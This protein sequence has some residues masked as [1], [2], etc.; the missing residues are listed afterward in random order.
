[1]N[2][3]LIWKKNHIFAANN[4]ENMYIH[5][6]KDWPNFIWEEGK[7]LKLLTKITKKQGRLIGRMESI[8]FQLQSE[9]VLRSITLEV[10]KSN[11]IE[12]E[13]LNP[14]QVRSSVARRLGL[15]IAGLIPSDRYVDGAVEMMLD[16]TQAYLLPLTKT[17]LFAWHNLLFPLNGN[18]SSK[19]VI[20]KWRN[21]KLDDPMQVVSGAM[22]KEKV[23]FQAPNS[24]LLS[25]EM[26]TFLEWFNKD[27]ELH[28]LLKAAVSHLWFVTLHPFDDGNGRVARAIAD[29]QLTRADEIPQ[30]FY[31]MS[32]Q[33]RIE[34]K[35]YY[36]ILEKTQKGSLDITDWIEWFIECL[37]R[38]IAAS[39]ETLSSII[40]KSRYWDLLHSKSLSDRQKMMINKLLDGFEGKLTSSKWAKISGCSQ[41]TAMRD[42]QNLIDQRILNREDAGGRSTNYKLIEID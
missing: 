36:S 16:A 32:S 3:L 29:M 23:H 1:M 13:L 17:R 11:E 24:D 42:I 2:E 10:L 21:N 34:R 5:Q 19:M 41:D 37:E 20:G 6:R 39:E 14:E 25:K 9:A 27:S 8:G 30:R 35:Q 26:K 33:I 40:K 28:P 12:G 18:S 31:S 7:L 4:A 38:A 15:D 22:G